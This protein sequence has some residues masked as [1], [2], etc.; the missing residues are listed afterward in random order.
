MS[1]GQ[2]IYGGGPDAKTNKRSKVEQA[3]IDYLPHACLHRRKPLLDEYDRECGFSYDHTLVFIRFAQYGIREYECS[4]CGHRAYQDEYNACDADIH[5]MLEVG[6][7][8]LAF[9]PAVY[10]SAKTMREAVQASRE[11]KARRERKSEEE[12]DLDPQR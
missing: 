3:D 6:A 8:E 4:N 9:Q 1:S 12:I 2:S 11:L 5:E 7:L 10:K